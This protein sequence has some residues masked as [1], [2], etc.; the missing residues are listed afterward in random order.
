[1]KKNIRKFPYEGDWYTLRELEAI[2]GY[3]KSTI[4][5][6][7]RRGKMTVE[8]AL[9]KPLQKRGLNDIATPGEAWLGLNP[10]QLKIM[11]EFQIRGDA[12]D[13]YRKRLKNKR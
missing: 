7:I 5:R 1:M 8:E 2:S 12:D 11:Q 4:W 10:D 9:A 13:R 3:G 6:R